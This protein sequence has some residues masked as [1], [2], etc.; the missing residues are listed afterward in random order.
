MVT[1]GRPSRGP[2]RRFMLSPL[3]SN[4]RVYLSPE[5]P[6]R[7]GQPALPQDAIA[8][9]STCMDETL[10]TLGSR[11]GSDGL[12]SH[13]LG[14]GS[15]HTRARVGDTDQVETLLVNEGGSAPDLRCRVSLGTQAPDSMPAEFAGLGTPEQAL[16]YLVE[17]NRAVRA[18]RALG[19]ISESHID[20]PIPL[21]SVR[22]AT[23]LELESAWL[24]PL[25]EGCTA[26]AFFV[27][28]VPFAS[29][30]ETLRRLPAET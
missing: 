15:Q 18:H 19:L 1:S 24:A 5:P 8:F 14:A 26:W 7:P 6:T 12:P 25:I 30:G 16:A 27:P 9:I 23:V 11:L 17:Q 29:L 28:S 3:Q 2:L 4:W 21:S 13:R 20:I 10:Y 22:A